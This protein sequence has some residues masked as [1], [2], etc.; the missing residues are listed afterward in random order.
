LVERL[1]ELA[2]AEGGAKIVHRERI[3]LD[4]FV[5]SCVGEL[6]ILAEYKK[7][8]LSVGTGECQVDADPVLLRQALQNLIDNAMKYSPLE[9]TIRIT[10]ESEGGECRVS[11]TD[12]GAGVPAEHRPHLADRFYRV[13]NSRVRGRGGF[14]LGLAITKAYMH[15]MGGR[16]EYGP[17]EPKGS[18]FALVLPE[19]G[20]A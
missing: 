12:Q 16:L 19:A 3:R 20:G 8:Q 7:Q 15:A 9:T 13:E 14:G 6:G 4:Q 18:C 5:T 2:S 11:V 17:A 1:L 10:V